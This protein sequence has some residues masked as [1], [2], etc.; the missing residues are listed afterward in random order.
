MQMAMQRVYGFDGTTI[1]ELANVAGIVCTLL[2]L[3]VSGLL[4]RWGLSAMTLV[5]AVASAACCL[6]R[7]MPTS[8]VPLNEF[9]YVG[10]GSMVL[11]GVAGA[12]MSTIG[13]SVAAAWFPASERA[14]ATSLMSLANYAGA[15]AGFVIGPVIVGNGTQAAV[16]DGVETLYVVEALVA[17]VG[18]MFVVIY[19]PS[20]PPHPPTRSTA[21]VRT[22]LTIFLGALSD[23]A[24]QRGVR[25]R[26]E[27][28]Y[29]LLTSA[30]TSR[31]NTR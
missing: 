20:A 6:L 22:Y 19:F 11:N 21:E 7:L 5:G 26:R 17:A 9:Q 23:A 14:V 4:E 29:R 28:L 16:Q 15:A 13:P 31:T 30:R 18:L 12:V 27:S 1:G 2:I 10:Y 24:K 8:V 3:P 25:G